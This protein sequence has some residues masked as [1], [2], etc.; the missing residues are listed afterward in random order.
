M[1]GMAAS[2]FLGDVMLRHAHPS[3]PV[4]PTVVTAVVIAIAWTALKPRPTPGL[5]GQQSLPV[6]QAVK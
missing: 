5:A 1:I 6:Q 4:V 3:A 2:A